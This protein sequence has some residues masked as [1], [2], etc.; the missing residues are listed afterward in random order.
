MGTRSE[1]AV[2]GQLLVVL[3]LAPTGTNNTT[4]LTISGPTLFGA[5]TAMNAFS[6]VPGAGQVWNALGRFPVASSGSTTV[7]LVPLL[8]GCSMVKLVPA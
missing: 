5:A 4:T 3:M 6:L 7:P 1:P 2:P 8:R